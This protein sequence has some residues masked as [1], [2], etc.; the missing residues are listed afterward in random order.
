MLARSSVV[1]RRESGCVIRFV[2]AAYAYV[3][4]MLAAFDGVRRT[5]LYPDLLD[6][7]CK[8]DL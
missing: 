4:D 7:L 2:Y 3:V 8:A 5:V 6:R 1:R